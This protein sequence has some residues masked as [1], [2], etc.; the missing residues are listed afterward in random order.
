MPTTK[1]NNGVEMAVAEACLHILEKLFKPFDP[2]TL[3]KLKSG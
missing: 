3:S 1:N 2:N